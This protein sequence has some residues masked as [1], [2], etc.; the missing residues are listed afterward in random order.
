MP[1]LSFEEL[2]T[3]T[4]L[5]KWYKKEREWV[6]K[7][8]SLCQIETS[9]VVFDLESEDSGYIA[10]IVVPTYQKDIVTGKTLCVLVDSAPLVEQYLLEKDGSTEPN[11]SE[12]SEAIQSKSVELLRI[13]KTLYE[14]KRSF[15]EVEY[16]ILKSMAWN[17]DI[18]LLTTFGGSYEGDY[19]DE[20][21]FD[22]CFFVENARDLAHEQAKANR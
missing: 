11:G 19:F 17:Q 14:E 21:K 5:T 3:G 9:D 4:V 7:G 20:S 2:A 10:E 18:R 1:D 6:D 8:D 12:T 13:L 22:E 16:K 15:T